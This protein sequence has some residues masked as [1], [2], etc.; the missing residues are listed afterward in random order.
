MNSPKTQTVWL[1][2]DTKEDAA[3]APKIALACSGRAAPAES[4]FS[5]LPF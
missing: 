1:P 2:R 5:C 4:L 3:K